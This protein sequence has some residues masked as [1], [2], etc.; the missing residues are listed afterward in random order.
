MSL[1]SFTAIS[2]NYDETLPAA[3]PLV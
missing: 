1:K 2:E 3:L